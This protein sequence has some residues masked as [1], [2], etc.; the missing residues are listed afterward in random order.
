MSVGEERGKRWALF[1]QKL[2]ERGLSAAAIPKV[3][4][5]GGPFA[6]SFAQERLLFLEQLTPGS[7]AYNDHYALRVTGPLDR[8][9]LLRVL[10]E[11][12]RRH[13]VLRTTFLFGPAGEGLQ[14]VH[15]EL[16]VPLTDQAWAP[17]TSSFEA[18]LLAEAVRE[19]QTPFD[20]NRGPLA[21]AR[22]L[23]RD[24]DLHVLLFTIHH[25]ISDGW[26]MSVL[27]K[28]ITTLYGA[29]ATGKPS[30][31]ADLQTQYVDYARWQ[32]ERFSPEVLAPKLAFWKAELEGAPLSIDIATDRPRPKLQSFAGKSLQRSFGPELSQKIAQSARELG[33][34]PFAILFASYGVLLA[35][36]SG[37]RDL[38]IA[39]PIAN[40]GRVELE[41][42]IGCFV[43]TLPVRLE[44][45]GEPTLATLA[46]QASD[47]L[48]RG[49]AHEDLPF[50][51]LVEALDIERDLSRSPIAQVMF[52]LQNTPATALEMQGLS[53]APLQVDAG[54]S[55]LDLTLD[56]RPAS[57]GY[58]TCWEYNTELFDEATIERLSGHYEQLLRRL[59]AQPHA[60]AFA[61]D[62]LAP[63]ERQRLLS[64]W[65]DTNLSYPRTETLHGLFARQA[66]E[67]PQAI[68]LVVGAQRF[69][70]AELE[71]RARGIARVL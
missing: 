68:A 70:Y 8:S 22:L 44:L 25:A 10:D 67:S 33:K 27:A 39:T 5:S 12:S 58:V 41:A 65:N 15:E 34:T 71:A 9:L 37:Q 4:R 11:I 24:R 26:S 47:R 31:L 21:R 61:G 59:I 30:P 53:F 49:Q 54:F 14:T 63:A 48:Q 20:L 32:R 40:R 42:L 7:A 66:R 36:Y 50:E 43:N 19:A 3:D 29:F 60:P 52:V 16:R 13:E 55:K 6:A 69:T 56:V 17:E 57:D 18:W 28:E 51:K 38:V 1:E 35:R 62:L 23:T 46:A 2:R 45:G 64:E